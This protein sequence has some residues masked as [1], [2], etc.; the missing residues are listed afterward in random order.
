MT[1]HEATALHLAAR[2]MATRMDKHNPHAAAKDETFS[3]Y[4]FR[5][6]NM[7]NYITYSD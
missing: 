1:L 3:W 2:L 6:L 7:H 4:L 5:E